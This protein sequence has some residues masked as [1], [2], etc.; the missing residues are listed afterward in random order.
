MF[1]NYA[2]RFRKAAGEV[3]SYADGRRL[4][5]VDLAT[6]ADG[7][8][9]DVPWSTA[10]VSVGATVELGDR[11]WTDNVQV[12]APCPAGTPVEELRLRGIGDD[13]LSDWRIDAAIAYGWRV[14]E[15]HGPELTERTVLAEPRDELWVDEG[16]ATV[17]GIRYY[18]VEGVNDCS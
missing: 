12:G 11:V 9:A 7:A 3:W 6:F 18:R 16:A 5:I 15:V 1:H 4:G 2:V 14:V 8:F 13:V 10:A 17:P